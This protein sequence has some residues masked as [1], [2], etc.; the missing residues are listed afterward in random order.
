MRPPEIV[1][2]GSLQLYQATEVVNPA[3]GN[4]VLCDGR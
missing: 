1:E 2:V 4:I 3:R